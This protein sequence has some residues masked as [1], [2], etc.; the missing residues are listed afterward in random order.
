MLWQCSRSGYD[1]PDGGIDEDIDQTDGTAIGDA[2]NEFEIDYDPDSESADAGEENGFEADDDSDLEGTNTEEDG[3]EYDDDS[4]SEATD[5]GEEEDTEAPQ[6]TAVT[7][8]NGA[9]YTLSPLVIVWVS[10]SDPN[11]DLGLWVRL[12]EAAGDGDC[13]ARYSN[14]NWQSYQGDYQLYSFLLSTGDGVKKVCAWAKDSQDNISVISPASGTPGTDCDTIIKEIDNIPQIITFEVLNGN[15]ASPNYHTRTLATGD[16][17]EVSWWIN[18]VEGL[19]NDPISLEFTT[20]DLTWNPILSD[21]GGLSGNPITYSHVY[22]GFSAPTDNYFRLRLLARDMAGNTSVRA[23]SDLL[24]TNAWNVY[25]GSTDRGIG[26]M[27]RSAKIESNTLYGRRF[28]ID[29]L[30]NDIYAADDAVGTVKLSATSGEVSIF[31]T[32]DSNNLPDNGLLPDNP[33]FYSY[34]AYQQFDHSGRLYVVTY[35]DG[36]AVVAESG[37]VYQIDLATNSVRRYIGGGNSYDPTASPFEILVVPNN[38]AFDEDDSLY[39]LSSCTPGAS[40]DENPIFR[41]MKVSQNPDGTAGTFSVVAGNCSAGDPTPGTLAID[42]PFPTDSV[43]KGRL[44]K[45]TVWNYGQVMY[46]SGSKVWKIIDGQFYQADNALDNAYDLTYE[47]LS[48]RLLVA[49]GFLTA[50]VPNLTGNGGEVLDQMLVASN[51]TGNCTADGIDRQNACAQVRGVVITGQGVAVFSDGPTNDRLR[52]VDPTGRVQTLLGTLPLYGDGLNKRFLR[53]KL[54]GIYFKQPMEQ[55]QAAF[56]MGLYFVS[57][58]ALVFGHI[59]ANA[60]VTSTLWG[61]QQGG[62]D[63]LIYP[64]GTEIS[65]ELSLGAK[66]AQ[67]NLMALGFE[68]GLPFLRY[69]NV[70]AKV[71]GQNQIVALQQGGSVW[72]EDFNGP[73]LSNSDLS[74]YGTRHNMSIK[75]GGIFLLGSFRTSDGDPEGSPVIRFFDFTSDTIVEVMG[76]K[77][78]SGFSPDTAVPGSVQGL[79]LDELCVGCDSSGYHLYRSDQDR[80]YFSEADKVRYISSPTDPAQSTLTSLFTG[81]AGPI[82]D[83]TLSPS[84]DKVFYLVGTFGYLYCYRIFGSDSWC[85]NTTNLG[86][87]GNLNSFRRGPNHFTWIDERT[88]LVSNYAGV[89]MQLNLDLLP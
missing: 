62:P 58:D 71:D 15:S 30:R 49:Q 39:F 59:D 66:D 43:S 60:E 21:F 18:D 54:G 41:L 73:D 28:A 23:L 79:T 17:V 56:P 63:N 88:L 80:L 27:G 89:V 84:G 13:Q 11:N 87:P 26:T 38:L 74:V 16:I 19:D 55:N 10:V 86:P 12:A 24:N 1:S 8:N 85:D 42:S 52:Y 33:T 46:I 78:L 40:K 3:F 9:Q 48:D 76:N 70:L 81:A 69:N 35:H 25:A 53:G 37:A 32:R 22:T 36:S 34:Y 14:D 61:N 65:P 68:E 50:Y 64:T 77:S 47:P 82:Q 7:I 29:P 57:P 4:D 72:W 20:D 31:A 6:V 83:F 44:P 2:S 51:G 5:S 45:L 67:G 75:D